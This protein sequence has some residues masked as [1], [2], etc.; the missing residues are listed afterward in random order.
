[1]GWSHGFREYRKLSNHFFFYGAIGVEFFFIVSGYLM[2][3]S[4]YN[5]ISRGVDG[6]DTKTFLWRKIKSIWIYYLSISLVMMI[7]KIIGGQDFRYILQRI[8]SLFFLQRTGAFPYAFLTTSWY[9]SSMLIAMAIIHPILKKYYQTFVDVIGPLVAIL[10]VGYIIH[11]SRSMLGITKWIGITYKCN[12]CAIAGIAM[13]TSCFEISRKMQDREYT[14]LQRCIISLL[15]ILNFILIMLFICSN[16]RNRY[17][18]Y[19]VYLFAGLVTLSFSSCG[20]LSQKGIF[21]KRFFIYLGSISLP[22]YL[23]QDIFRRYGPTI[24]GN[25]IVGKMRFI[26]TVALIIVSAIVMHFVV[27]FIKGK[28]KNRRALR[29]DS[30]GAKKV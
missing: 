16:E 2:A 6:L 1:M 19:L 24:I 7:L 14:N 3:K 8:P 5:D 15:A 4:V 30:D 22:I 28:M 12:L 13:G 23:L 20:Y 10:L 9:L 25:Q 21:Q 29:V 17:T 26:I 11:E 27:E 18:A